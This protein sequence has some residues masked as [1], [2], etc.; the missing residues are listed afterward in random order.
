MGVSI[1]HKRRHARAARRHPARP[2][3]HVDDDQRHRRLAA[4]ALHRRPPRSNGV[5]AGRAP[6]HDPERH[7]QGVPGARHLRVPTRPVDAAD[8]GHDRLHGRATCRSGTRSTSAPTTSRRRARRRSRRSPTRSRTADGRARRGAR[9]SRRRA[10]PGACS[11]R[12]SFFVNAGIR[13]IEEHAK[14][15]AMGRLWEELGPRALRR[16]RPALPALPLRRAGQLAG[17]DRVAAREQRAADRAR[18]AR[19]HA[20]P[21]RARPRP[22]AAGLERGAR[23]AARLGPAVVAAHPADPRLRDRH[24]RVPRHLRGLARDGGPR[25]RAGRGC[26]RG[27]GCRGRARRRRRRRDLH[28]AQLVESHRAR[29]APDRARRPD[30]RR[31]STAT[32]RPSPRR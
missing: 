9:A 15:R 22:A 5:D 24:A 30:G 28:E 3:E 23:P 20:R 16:D 25:G 31:A 4:R 14:L 2:D 19:R 13:F 21:Q 32:P 6:G 10:L 29:I 17:A 11:A 1:A 7:H 12:I 26:P 27:D 8:R 18:G